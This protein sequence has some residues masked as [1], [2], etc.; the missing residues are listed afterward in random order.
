MVQY[1]IHHSQKQ[2]RFCC[3]FNRY[4]KCNKGNR[5]REGMEEN[6]EAYNKGKQATGKVMSN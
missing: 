5:K 1:S 3:N 6:K 4:K 2:L